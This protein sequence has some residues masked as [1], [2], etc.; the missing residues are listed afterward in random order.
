MTLNPSITLF[1]NGQCEAAF[2]F[3]EKCLG[4]QLAY[5]LTWGDSPMAKDAPPEWAGKILH[6][7]LMLGDTPLLGADAL[8]GTYEPPRG[9]GLML[10]PDDLEDA[11]RL[12]TALA[13]NGKVNVPFQE[14]FWAR[15]YGHVTDQFGIPWEINCEK[16]PE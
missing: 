13:E 12:C 10:H 6:A 3:Y 8:P 14:T 15:R 4:G 16:S 9:F 11:E 5:L 2:R 7:R 1:F